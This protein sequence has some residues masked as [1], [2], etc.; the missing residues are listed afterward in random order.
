MN[1]RRWLSRTPAPA[2]LRCDGQAMKLEGGRNQ[3]ATAERSI[4]T[5]NPSKLEALGADGSILR[6]LNFAAAS[7]EPDVDKAA[8]V[9][10]SE[11]AQLAR[12]IGDV[13]DRAALRHAEAYQAAFNALMSLTTVL[14]K[15]L[16]SIEMAYHR[17]IMQ[18][19]NQ[20]V[21]VEGE[22]E[23]DGMAKAMMMQ[24]LMGGALQQAP[25]PNGK[26]P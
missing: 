14:A 6:V 26:K 24:T 7:A 4:E 1:L 17:N 19:A 25:P 18:R 13:G 9:V 10:E 21:E 22:D 11:T 12:V 23:L 3:Y 15:R 20:T 16:T 8:P 5:L 2:S